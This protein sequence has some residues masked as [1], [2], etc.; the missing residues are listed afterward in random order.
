MEA[1]KSRVAEE[2][3]QKVEEHVEHKKI[4]Q[5]VEM[6]TASGG[7]YGKMEQLFLMG[8]AVLLIFALPFLPYAEGIILTIF[9]VILGLAAGFT[10]PKR[11]YSPRLNL[12]LSLIGIVFFEY[13]AIVEFHI[14]N[15]G[16]LFFV[17][18]LLALDFM[19]GMYFSVL[20]FRKM[21]L[22]RD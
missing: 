5:Q 17:Y 9:A 1:E 18:Q 10:S 22:E 4:L 20:T 6:D 15:F 2:L 16:G 21:V 13:S 8:A 12:I 3:L 11:A 19:V 7:S 14:H